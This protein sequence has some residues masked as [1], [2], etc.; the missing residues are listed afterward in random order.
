MSKFRPFLS[1]LS[2]FRRLCWIAS[3][4]VG[5]RYTS[6]LPVNPDRSSLP[7][8]LESHPN[9]RQSLGW[10]FQIISSELQ[11][12]ILQMTNDRMNEKTYSKKCVMYRR[13]QFDHETCTVS[14]SKLGV[15]TCTIELLLITAR[16]SHPVFS[17]VSW[18][19]PKLKVVKINFIKNKIQVICH[20]FWFIGLR[21][22][23]LWPSSCVIVCANVIPLSSLTLHERFGLHIPPTFATPSVLYSFFAMQWNYLFNFQYLMRFWV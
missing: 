14:A 3:D 9:N 20:P 23:H 8:P 13:L 12:S 18:Y 21:N 10:K 1:K 4:I 6:H 7:F 11:N 2:P 15:I 19:I 16:L 5:Q 17:T 22:T